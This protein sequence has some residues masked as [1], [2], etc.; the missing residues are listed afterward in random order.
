[1]LKTS[2]FSFCHNVFKFY[3]QLCLQLESFSLNLHR[4][5]QRRLLQIFFMWERV[6]PLPPGSDLLSQANCPIDAVW[7]GS[8]LLAVLKV[9]Y[10]DHILSVI[11]AFITIH[12]SFHPIF[13]KV[14]LSRTNISIKPWPSSKL[15]HMK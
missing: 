3:Q 9:I 12:V 8:M 7:A 14:Y 2:N 11:L 13:L 6:N 10:C 15:G 4:R 5:F 1:M